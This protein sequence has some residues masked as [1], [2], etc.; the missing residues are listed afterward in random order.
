MLRESIEDFIEVA[1]FH[2]HFLVD[3]P[4]VFWSA[5]DLGGDAEFAEATT[6]VFKN[7]GQVDIALWGTGGHHVIDFCISL[8]VKRSETKIFKLLFKLLHAK[9]MGKWRINV[10]GL[11]R[12][13][14]LLPCGH[15]SNGPHVVQSIGKLDDQDAEI[16]GHRHEHFAN[17]GRL[18]CFF[19]VELDSIKFCD[20]VH[21]SGD[22]L[23]EFF[24]DINQ[25]CA[26]VFYCIV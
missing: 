22:V 24:L 20:A 1:T 23:T 2:H 12:R 25:G 3:A 8:W 17:S 9:A 15:C 7:I 11:L 21:N 19:A 14:M 18:L 10:E 4:Q 5:C 13:A 26:G 16:F 6:D